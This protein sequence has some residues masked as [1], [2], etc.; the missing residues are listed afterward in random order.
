MF[1]RYVS[2]SEQI[3]T[4]CT[5]DHSCLVIRNVFHPRA[6]LSN[7]T[8]NDTVF[9]Y[10]AN[11]MDNYQTWRSCHD[12]FWKLDSEINRR[13]EDDDADQSDAEAVT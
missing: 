4:A 1:W 5:L 7:E 3:M 2:K 10:K 8:T 6:T 12:D 11:K 9:W 13:D